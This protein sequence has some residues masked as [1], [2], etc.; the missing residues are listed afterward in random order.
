MCANKVPARLTVVVV[1][2]PVRDNMPAH[3]RHHSP[4]RPPAAPTPPESTHQVTSHTV[5]V[6]VKGSRQFQK[7]F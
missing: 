1:S 4:A 6:L 2:R 7:W 5:H 3:R